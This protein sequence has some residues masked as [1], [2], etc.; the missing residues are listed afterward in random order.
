MF[1]SLSK[2]LRSPGVA[3]KGL[4][5]HPDNEHLI[6]PMGNRVTIKNIETGR[7]KFLTGHT[8]VISAVCVSPCGKYVGSGQI[9]HVGFKVR[10]VSI[11]SCR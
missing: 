4:Q 6:Y 9:N 7:Q 3:N 11:L 2:I 8:N 1:P 5:L 10:T